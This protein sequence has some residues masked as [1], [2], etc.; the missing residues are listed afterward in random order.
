MHSL[1]F[2]TQLTKEL[3]YSTVVLQLNEILEKNNNSVFTVL[4]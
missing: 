3:H 1:I 2:L 4:L